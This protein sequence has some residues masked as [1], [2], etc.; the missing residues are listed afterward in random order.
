MDGQLTVSGKVELDGVGDVSERILALET[1]LAT[2]L[3]ELKAAKAELA[4]T[5]ARE[6]AA[7]TGVLT[8][9][10]LAENTNEDQQRMVEELE[11]KSELCASKQALAD[12]EEVVS[13]LSSHRDANVAQHA[14]CA[15][16][17]SDD[18]NDDTTFCAFCPPGTYAPANSNGPCAAKKCASGTTDNDYHS[19][20][21]CLACSAGFYTAAGNIGSCPF[22]P[23][24]TSDH[25]SNPKTPCKACTAGKV[26]GPQ[27]VGGCISC[28]AGKGNYFDAAAKKCLKCADG[29]IDDD[30][31]VMTRCSPKPSKPPQW[32]T[33]AHGNV[34]AH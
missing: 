14:K 19:A 22:C 9:V 3:A 18:D 33:K 11:D 16:G 6:D 25:D 32:A 21:A 20:T 31:D 15:A 26:A 12:V 7:F 2:T 28:L 23:L 8:R 1:S 10:Q 13:L 4:A 30:G 29:T 17:F 24:G 27:T 5:S 34:K